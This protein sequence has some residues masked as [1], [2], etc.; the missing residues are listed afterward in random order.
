MT[1]MSEG[2]REALG[3]LVSLVSKA[4]LRIDISPQWVKI[5]WVWNH[6]HSYRGRNFEHKWFPLTLLGSDEE[7]GKQRSMINPK[8]QQLR[9]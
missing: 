4:V 1:C 6:L 9:K 2:H 5:H 8:F 3:S 7:L